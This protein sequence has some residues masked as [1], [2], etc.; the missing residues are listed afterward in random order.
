MGHDSSHEEEFRGILVVQS[1]ICGSPLRAWGGVVWWMEIEDRRIRFER[2]EEAQEGGVHLKC[3]CSLAGR[4]GVR[5]ATALE[6]RRD[7]R[8][9]GHA[10]GR[11]HSVEKLPPEGPGEERLPDR[12]LGSVPWRSLQKRVER[13]S[14]WGGKEMGCPGNP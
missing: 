4:R 5:G 6:C 2:S 7:T 10:H 1:V 3:P 9:V 13:G 14:R 8:R 12:N 11:R